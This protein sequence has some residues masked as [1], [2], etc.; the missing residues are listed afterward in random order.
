MTALLRSQ[1]W[2]KRWFA[3]LTCSLFLLLNLV[4][5]PSA[6][7]V[8]V[9]DIPMLDPNKPTWVL[10]QSE[11]VSPFNQGKLN[12]QL[13][14]LAQDTG[15]QVHFIAVRRL[16]YG[17]TSQSVVDKLFDQ[18]ILLLDTVTNLAAIHAG[19]AAQ[20][21]LTPEIANSITEETL[22]VPLKENNYNQAFL[23]ASARLG[24][25]LRGEADPGPPEVKVVNT[26]E[27]TFATAEE[28]NDQTATII[29]VVLLIVA[30]VVPMVTYFWY[31][32]GS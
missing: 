15:N 29:V 5:I 24:A 22:R 17:E 6:W 18:V 16:D 26:V 13:K 28:T 25:V 4:V 30:T 1:S 10:D 3:G 11:V 12:G 32:S 20:A 23:D 14:Q 9:F 21:L 8:G 7:A 31:Q 2:L 27:G 19:E